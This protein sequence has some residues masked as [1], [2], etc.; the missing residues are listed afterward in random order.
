MMKFQISLCAFLLS[1]VSSCE[2]R[3]NEV[4]R[5]WWLYGSG[6]HI[7]DQLGNLQRQLKNDTIYQSR[8]PVAIIYSTEKGFF[9]SDDEI[10]IQAIDSDE[11]GYY[12]CKGN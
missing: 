4:K 1:I 12:H 11:L 8:I 6:Y 5:V 3:E 2:L 10:V 7:G 9:G